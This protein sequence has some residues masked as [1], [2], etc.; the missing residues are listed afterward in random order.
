VNKA[1]NEI[2]L[3]SLQFCRE[4]ISVE[5]AFFLLFNRLPDEYVSI[6]FPSASKILYRVCWD[7]FV[8]A[9]SL[10]KLMRLNEYLT[11]YVFLNIYMLHSCITL[12]RSMTSVCTKVDMIFIQHDTRPGSLYFSRQ[13][14]WVIAFTI[15]GECVITFFLLFYLPADEF[16]EDW[17]GVTIA[18]IN[19]T[20]VKNKWIG[21]SLFLNKK[22][23]TFLSTHSV[24]C[25]PIW[26]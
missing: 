25:L 5:Y 22:R 23:H 19:S 7:N 1:F 15:K 9:I 17:L 21:L 4:Q 13:M 12:V 3:G 16:N 2:D 26:F 6:I 18:A 8:I 14:N 24:S 20:P 10:N 11:W